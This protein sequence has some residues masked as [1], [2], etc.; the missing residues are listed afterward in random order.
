M[1][2]AVLIVDDE[3]MVAASLG[4]VLQVAGIAVSAVQTIDDALE[5]LDRQHYDLVVAD[6]SLKGH[7]GREGFQLLESMRHQGCTVRAV[8]LT[9]HGGAAVRDEAL[10]RGFVDYLIKSMPTEELLRRIT[11]TLAGT[12]RDTSPQQ[13]E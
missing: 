3:P 9:G 6:L 2:T 5:A 10:A 8:M 11:S 4:P 7:D 12:A 13:D 1:T